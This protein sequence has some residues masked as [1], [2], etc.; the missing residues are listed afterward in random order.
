MV[1]IFQ[2]RRQNLDLIGLVSSIA[3]AVINIDLGRKSWAI[4]GKEQEGRIS[5]EEGIAAALSAFENAQIS[6]DPQAIVLAEYTYLS[7]ELE[8]CR[9]TDNDSQSSLT[10]AKQNFDDALLALQI[11]EDNNLYKGVEKTYLHNSK[12]RINGLPKDAFHIACISHRTRLQNILRVPG[13]DSIEK[14][15]LK[16]R[17]TNLSTAQSGYIAKQKKALTV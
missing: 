14:S 16:Q 2:K 8:L 3:D 17:L 1:G 4:R 9:E 15:L 5:F 11:V 13:V 10:Q 12:Y 6:T 7:Q